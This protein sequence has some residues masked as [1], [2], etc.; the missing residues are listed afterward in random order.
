LLLA[1]V[2]VFLSF[3]IYNLVVEKKDL[4]KE[5]SDLKATLNN[6]EKENNNLN[7]KIEYFNHP[8]NLLKELK[9]QSNYRNPSEKLIIIVPSST[10]SR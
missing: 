2:F 8:E 1:V 4:S 9:S 6:Y 3:G 5:I 7:S 10:Q